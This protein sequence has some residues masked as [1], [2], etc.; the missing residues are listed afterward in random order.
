MS[1]NFSKL[2]KILIPIGIVVWVFFGFML[3]QAIG[4]ALIQVLNWAGVPLRS[5]N[6]TLFNT[7]ANIVIYA[8]ALLIIIG[9][10]TYA[11]LMTSSHSGTPAKISATVQDLQSIDD[12]AQVFQQLNSLDQDDQSD[13]GSSGNNL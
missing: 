9:G 12:N 7:L 8:V 2:R 1:L 13:N 10:G 11:D 5:L 6:S 4:I 3:A